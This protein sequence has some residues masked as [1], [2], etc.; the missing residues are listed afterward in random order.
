MTNLKAVRESAGLSQSQLSKKSGVNVRTLQSY[1]RGAKNI[2]GAK[3]ETLLDL[4]AAL[5][6]KIPDILESER[7]KEKLKNN[8]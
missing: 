1:E 8:G 2:D 5:E 7:L 6:C 4:S 3:L